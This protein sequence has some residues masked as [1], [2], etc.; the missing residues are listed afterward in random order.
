MLEAL[1]LRPFALAVPLAESE[2]G[3]AALPFLAG[4]AVVLAGAIAF[5]VWGIL[6]RLDKFDAL[7]QKLEALEQIRSALQA[8]AKE[9]SDLDLRR[10]EHVLIE[11]R[12]GQRRLEDAILRAT[13]SA[14]QGALQGARRSGAH[15][16]PSAAALANPD[17]PAQRIL[18]RVLAQG[19]ERV[20]IVPDSAEIQRLIAAGGLQEVLVEARRNGV[21]CK[22][23]VL[24][25]DGA[26]T[27]VELTPA[28]TM[29]P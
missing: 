7:T 1:E 26:V 2:W 16:D 29:F 8:L 3:A 17:D 20:Q 6:A 13:Q 9:R 21:L 18:A 4:L 24:L 27:D 25:R 15:D 11:M 5:G 22:G 12:D 23:R 28:Y 14:L 10:I 19:F